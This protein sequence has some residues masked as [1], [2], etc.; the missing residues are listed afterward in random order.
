MNVSYEL[1]AVLKPLGVAIHATRRAQM[2]KGDS[3]LIFGAGAVGLLC[4]AMCKVTG[5]AKVVIADIQAERVDFA[6]QNGFS[7][8][9]FVVPRKRGQ[10]VDDNLEIARATA[11]LASQVQIINGELPFGYERVFECTGVEACTQSAIYVHI[12]PGWK[13]ITDF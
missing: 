6:V 2:K 7:H 12:S 4:A 11:R 3:T 1:G 13:G 10:N 5:S 9:G 8:A